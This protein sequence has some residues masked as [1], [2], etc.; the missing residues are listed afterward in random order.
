MMR[1]A[2]SGTGE[3]GHLVGVGSSGA[4]VAQSADV[5]GHH[6]ARMDPNVDQCELKS[7]ESGVNLWGWHAGWSCH[8]RGHP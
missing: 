1:I 7:H 5:P 4:V 6:S 2:D 3:V 8:N